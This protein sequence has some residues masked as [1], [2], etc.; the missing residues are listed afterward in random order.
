MGV[1][2]SGVGDYFLGNGRQV[3]LREGVDG[4][5]LVGVEE[6]SEFASLAVPISLGSGGKR[7]FSGF[8]HSWRF[9]D[10]LETG[11]K[12]SCQSAFFYFIMIAPNRFMHASVSKALRQL[13]S[14]RS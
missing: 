7:S 1:V 8:H 10:R 4:A 6:G 13:L 9:V 12:W 2:E 3:S 14:L 11:V 5:R